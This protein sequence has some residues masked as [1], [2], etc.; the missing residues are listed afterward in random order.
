MPRRKKNQVSKVRKI[1]VPLADVGFKLVIGDSKLPLAIRLQALG[2]L[3]NPSQQFLG[4]VIRDP[5]TPGRLRMAASEK[6]AAVQQE[7]FERQLMRHRERSK[8]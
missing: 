3:L 7:A 1:K 5:N 4:K 8:Q 2:K 6:L